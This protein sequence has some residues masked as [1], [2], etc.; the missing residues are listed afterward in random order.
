MH[1]LAIVI[2]LIACSNSSKPTTQAGPVGAPMD[3]R[4]RITDADVRAKAPADDKATKR[5]LAIDV[6]GIG[7]KVVWRTYEVGTAKYIVSA[8][9]EVVTP[10]P[11]FTLE[12][13]GHLNPENV[14]TPEAPVQS[15]IVRVRWHDNTSSVSTSGGEM[16]VRIAADGQAAKI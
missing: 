16:S 15:E 9:W 1:K 10:K 7:A 6:N 12:S 11:G 5:E 4:E 14:G 2:A 13:L 8:G 3:L